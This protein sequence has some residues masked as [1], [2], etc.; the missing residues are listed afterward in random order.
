[1]VLAA[2]IRDVH[3]MLTVLCSWMPVEIAFFVQRMHSTSINYALM[4]SP[5]VYRY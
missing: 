5:H 1:M 2:I 3:V 4:L